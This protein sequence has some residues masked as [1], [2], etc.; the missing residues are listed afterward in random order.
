MRK[1]PSNFERELERK[2]RTLLLKGV[3]WLLISGLVGSFGAA[4]ILAA[5]HRFA[6][7][8]VGWWIVGL[9]WGVFVPTAVGALYTYVFGVLPTLPKTEKP[10][11]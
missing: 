4:L 7:Y 6:G 3:F 8:D 11:P 2:T 9:L 5:L 1:Y 10:V